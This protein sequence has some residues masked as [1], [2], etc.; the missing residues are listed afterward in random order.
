[1]TE[2]LLPLEQEPEVRELIARALSEDVGP[3]DATTLA[4]V[5]ADAEASARIVAR[6]ELV[7]A[8]VRV[9]GEVFRLAD[10]ALRRASAAGSRRPVPRSWAW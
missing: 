8:G 1:M 9:A 7:L 4:L 2:D 5:D 6:H 3:G 10:P